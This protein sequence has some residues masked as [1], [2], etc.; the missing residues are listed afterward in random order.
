MRR[1]GK[2]VTIL[3]RRGFGFTEKGGNDEYVG[4]KEI[5]KARETQTLTKR[6][7]EEEMER[8]VKREGG[9]EERRKEI[10]TTLCCVVT[11]EDLRKDGGGGL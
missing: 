4:E 2:R 9:K 7:Q 1:S 10:T 11:Q 5:E 6:G 3:Q 8:R